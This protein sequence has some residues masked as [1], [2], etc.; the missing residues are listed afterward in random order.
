VTLITS[1]DHKGIKAALRARFTGVLWQRC[2]VHLQRNAQA[3]V[4]KVALRCKIAEELR[5]IFNAADR[6]EAE[7]KLKGFVKSWSEKAPKLADWAEEN[8]PEGFA[9]YDL[10]LTESQR[11]KLRSSNSIENLNQQVKRR[12]RVARLFPNEASLLRLASAVLMEIS[13]EWE[14]GRRY[15]PSDE[16]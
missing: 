10:G 14:A 3:Y 4:P 16:A 12:T 13:E 11:K 6:P 1:D 7:R 8:V 15:L 9:V 2:Q 5:Q